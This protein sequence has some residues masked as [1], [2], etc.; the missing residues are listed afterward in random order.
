MDKVPQIM[1]QNAQGRSKI[2]TN[3]NSWNSQLAERLA[4]FKEKNTG[5]TA[6]VIESAG[7]FD[8]A[9][10]SPKSYGAPDATC[11]NKNGKSCLWWDNLHPGEQIQKLLAAEVAKA[12]KGS[13]F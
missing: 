5:V 7:P 11:L 4:T 6:V 2:M 8:T 10:S 1:G 12:W 3:V 9:I 13:F